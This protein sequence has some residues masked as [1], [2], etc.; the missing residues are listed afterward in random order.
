M[1]KILLTALALV[2]GLA[3]FAQMN[4]V[5]AGSGKQVYED[6]TKFQD[7]NTVCYVLDSFKFNLGEAR[8]VGGIS[9]MRI[10]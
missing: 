2:I 1:E 8:T 9:C 4:K 10:K 3:L 7:G 6:V 5:K